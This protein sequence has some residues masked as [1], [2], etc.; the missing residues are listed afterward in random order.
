MSSSDKEAGA[1]LISPDCLNLFTMAAQ[2]VEMAAAGDTNASEVKAEQ[3]PTCRGKDSSF[4]KLV[5]KDEH[6]YYVP[7]RIL[8]YSETLLNMLQG[9]SA[10]TNDVDTNEIVLTEISSCALSRICEYLSYYD[11]NQ[12]SWY[13]VPDF[14]LEEKSAPDILIA[15]C[16]LIIW[17][18]KGKACLR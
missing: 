11:N 18:Q 9:P 17:K 8:K 7:R 10:V 5:S 15:A 1:F 2:D 4:V 13:N 14:P 16:F 3:P 6:I 12:E